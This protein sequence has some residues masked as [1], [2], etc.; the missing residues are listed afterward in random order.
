MVAL[1]WMTPCCFIALGQLN[2][3][4]Q[5][6]RKEEE[7]DQLPITAPGSTSVVEYHTEPTAAPGNVEA[8]ARYDSGS[9]PAAAAD[10]VP[11]HLHTLQSDKVN[12]PV[13]HAG[14]QHGVVPV[15]DTNGGLPG[16]RTY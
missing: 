16:T 10:P 8:P 14:G 2:Y 4:Q 13:A 9:H 1:L 12:M 3:Y 5:Q 7:G 11:A 6:L 15:A